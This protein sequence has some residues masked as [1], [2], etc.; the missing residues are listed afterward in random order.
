MDLT[1]VEEQLKKIPEEIKQAF[2]SVETAKEIDAIG[3]ENGLL[4]DQIDILVKET[5]YAM[6]GAKP[7]G[8][9]VKNI[10]KEIGI[11][12]KVAAKIAEDINNKVLL[13]LREKIRN[14]EEMEEKLAEEARS[15]EATESTTNISSIEK[16]GG[17]SVIKD[18]P[19]MAEGVTSADRSAILSGVENPP[20]SQPA[21]PSV[22]AIA[23]G[24]M[25]APAPK[26][27]TNTEPLIDQLLSGSVSSPVIKT[28]TVV[29]SVAPKH[30]LPDPYREPTK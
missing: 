8:D 6:I 24:Q 4:I 30:K 5:G 3:T 13:P 22:S 14:R 20:G 12:N 28:S 7:A 19:E 17:F 26:V 18:K 9:F 11:D 27:E 16:A 1:K 29:E 10:T 25:M 15:Q 21:V 23:A 2:F